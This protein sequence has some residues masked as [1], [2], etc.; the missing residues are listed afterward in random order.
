MLKS[1]AILTWLLFHPVHVTLTSIDQVPD[2][3]SLKV[4]VKMYYDDFLLDYQ[5]FAGSGTVEDLPSGQPFPEDLLNKYIDEKVN[6]YINN[7]RLK[8]KLLNQDLSDNELKLNLIYISGKKPKKITVKN[9][10]MTNLYYDQANM[11]IIRINN[12]EEGIKLTPE[13]IEQ[14]FSVK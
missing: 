13:I 5:L 12:L 1:I 14:T 6:I 7:K 4:F 11:A 3:D 10:I 8:G 9:T 2:S